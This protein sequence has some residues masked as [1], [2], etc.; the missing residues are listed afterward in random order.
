[1]DGTAHDSSLLSIPCDALELEALRLELVK[2]KEEKE[3]LVRTIAWQ[4]RKIK[5]LETELR[6]EHGAV[7]GEL[8]A[9]V[10]T[11]GHTMA[12]ELRSQQSL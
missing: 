7:D 8:T 12:L 6:A 5:E 3:K 10:H 1:M 9:Q 4:E 11:L 2:E